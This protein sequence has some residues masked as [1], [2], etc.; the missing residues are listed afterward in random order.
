[1]SVRGYPSFTHKI[2]NSRVYGL[3][4]RVWL[5]EDRRGTCFRHP[6]AVEQMF[7]NTWKLL[8]FYTFDNFGK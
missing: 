5:D 7:M 1:M 4:G 8:F 3:I 6:V 2:R